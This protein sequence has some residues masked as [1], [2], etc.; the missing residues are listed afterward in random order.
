VKNKIPKP[1]WQN[2]GNLGP[3]EGS[4]VP[5]APSEGSLRPQRMT[6]PPVPN[7]RGLL[8]PLQP[9]AVVFFLLFIHPANPQFAPALPK[10]DTGLS[11][12]LRTPILYV[13]VRIDFLIMNLV[14]NRQQEGRLLPLFVC[15]TNLYTLHRRFGVDVVR[16]RLDFEMGCYL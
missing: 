5:S 2:N 11:V 4:S 8:R 12:L 9:T 3:S 14:L 16:I 15:P 7:G 1:G 10:I 13:L 6:H